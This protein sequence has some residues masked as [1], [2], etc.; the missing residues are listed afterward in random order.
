MNV[1]VYKLPNSN[2]GLYAN[3]HSCHVSTPKL[4]AALF[5]LK[6]SGGSLL[7]KLIA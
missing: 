5:C 4:K 2:N 7:A 3:M 6:Y 1:C